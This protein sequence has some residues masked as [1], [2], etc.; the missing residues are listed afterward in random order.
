MA[1]VRQGVLARALSPELSRRSFLRGAI[2]AAVA[3]AA[4]PLAACG[5]GSTAD[6]NWR[7]MVLEFAEMP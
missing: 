1:N 5:G 2:G 3:A 6:E 4:M 7:K